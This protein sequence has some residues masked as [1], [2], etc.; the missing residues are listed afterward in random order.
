MCDQILVTRHSEKPKDHM[1]AAA[2]KAFDEAVSL[3]SSGDLDKALASFLKA[4]ELSPEDTEISY[5]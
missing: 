3:E 1:S 5:A 2:R 4:Q